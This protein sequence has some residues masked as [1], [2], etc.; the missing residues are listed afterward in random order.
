M[1]N[2]IFYSS[3]RFVIQSSQGTLYV[4]TLNVGNL[5]KNS[6]FNI[7]SKSL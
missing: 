6:T 2:A 7:D 4:E 3:R 5:S 1:K